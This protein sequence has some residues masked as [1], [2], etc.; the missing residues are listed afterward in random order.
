MQDCPEC[1][2]T[3]NELSLSDNDPTTC[4]DLSDDK[5][6]ETFPKQELYPCMSNIH[7]ALEK[8]IWIYSS[9]ISK[10]VVWYLIT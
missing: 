7:N 1:P 10:T 9:R 6:E 4:G 5:L 2:C 8:L 3:D